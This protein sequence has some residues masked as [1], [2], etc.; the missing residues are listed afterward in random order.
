MKILRGTI[1]G[2]IVY[3]FVGWLIYGILLMDFF[4][5]DANQCANRP[6]GEMIWWAMILSNLAGSLLLT[7]ILYWKKARGIVDGL[8]TGAIFGALFTTTIDMSFWSMTTIYGSFT[9][10][11]A[12]IAVSAAIYG[13]MGLVIVLTWGKK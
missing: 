4:S 5:A 13:L 8:I 2:A 1:F 6:E 10:V 12:E 7:L 9:P 11:V 3:F